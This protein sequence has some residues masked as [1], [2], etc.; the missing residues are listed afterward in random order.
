MGTIRVVALLA[1]LA[2]FTV[3]PARGQAAFTDAT[4]THIPVDADLHSLDAEFGDFDKDGDL[5]IA[6]AVEGGTNRLYLND[7]KAVFTHKAGVFS[8]TAADGEDLAV[9][10]F[11]QDGN[12]DVIFVMEDGGV[13][14]FYLG[15]GDATFRNVSD[16]IPRCEANGVEAADL[17]GECDDAVA[18]ALDLRLPIIALGALMIL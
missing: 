11:D 8:A 5:D 16:R 9:E 6:E 15:N 3:P 4:S 12:L 2:A 17:A 1:A 13:H 14:Q 10:D 18:G 7:G